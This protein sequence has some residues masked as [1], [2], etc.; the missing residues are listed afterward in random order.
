M[1]V[2]CTNLHDAPSYAWVIVATGWSVQALCVCVAMIIHTFHLCSFH[3]F[4]VA[5]TAVVVVNS[6]FHKINVPT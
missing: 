5:A 6:D 3:Y 2:I 4:V 1:H